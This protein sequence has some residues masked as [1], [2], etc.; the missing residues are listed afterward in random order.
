[1][2]AVAIRGRGISERHAQS[3]DLTD[4]PAGHAGNALQLS[5]EDDVHR[6][7]ARYRCRHGES[8]CYVH[9]C[10]VPGRRPYKPCS[11]TYRR[12]TY[13]PSN[14]DTPNCPI[15]H[16]PSGLASAP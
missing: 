2:F 4:S 14:V 13:T 15:P 16:H 1:M 12:H 7:W 8:G 5:L 9:E 11:E 3:P 10:E 6:L